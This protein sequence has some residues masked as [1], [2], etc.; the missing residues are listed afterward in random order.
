MLKR[1][2]SLVLHSLCQIE[3]LADQNKTVVN[4]ITDVLGMCQVALQD[5][6]NKVTFGNHFGGRIHRNNY[7]VYGPMEFRVC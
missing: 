4:K 6:L 5:W 2:L 7:F 1:A 3:F